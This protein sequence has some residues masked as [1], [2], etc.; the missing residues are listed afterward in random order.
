MHYFL[1]KCKCDTKVKIRLDI[2]EH[3]AKMHCNFN[4]KIGTCEKRQLRQPFCKEVA[5]LLTQ[6]S[7]ARYRLQEAEQLMTLGDPEPPTF[8]SSDAL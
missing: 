4:V 6:K 8:P 3:T 7:A 2:G 1:G 5:K